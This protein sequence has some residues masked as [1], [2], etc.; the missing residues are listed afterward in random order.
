VPATRGF[1][2]DGG[3]A[4]AALLFEPRAVTRCS[5]GDMFIADTGNHRVRRIS[6]DQ[7]STVLGDGVAGSSGGG[8]PSATYPVHAPLGVACD[9]LGN[10]VATSTTS[11]RLIAADDAG[12]VDGSTAVFTIYGEAPRNTFPASVT[13]CLTGI[14][15]ADAESFQILDCTGLLVE[16]RRGAGP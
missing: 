1:A 12:H 2:G 9:A 8:A 5:N 3:A 16:L 4:T 6:A 10:V 11:V 13:S 15:V 7:I 14:A